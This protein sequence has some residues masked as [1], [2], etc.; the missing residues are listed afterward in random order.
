MTKKTIKKLIAGGLAFVCAVTA[1]IT[2]IVM[3]GLTAHDSDNINHN[4]QMVLG[5]FFGNGITLTANAEETTAVTLTY[6]NDYNASFVD[7]KS[8]ASIQP[9]GITIPANITLTAKSGYQFG[10][11]RVSD[12]SAPTSATMLS[13]NWVDTY[14]TTSDGTYG[15]AI[16]KTD[17]SDFDFSTD[18]IYIADYIDS[19]DT[20][21]FGSV[22]SGSG[23][24][25]PSVPTGV[26]RLTATITPA[27][28]SIQTVDWKVTWKN[29]S[30][31]WASGKTVTD[32]VNITPTEDGALTADIECQ[33]AFG[34]QV[35][36]TVTS[37]D[38]P[39]LTANCTVD[40]AKRI[41]KVHFTL[42][43][44]GLEPHSSAEDTLTLTF[45]FSDAFMLYSPGP[46]YEYSIGTV[47]DTYELTA[48]FYVD[49]DEEIFADI[50]AATGHV[51]TVHE[52]FLNGQFLGDPQYIRVFFKVDGRI[53][54]SSKLEEIELLEKYFYGHPEAVTKVFRMEIKVTGAYS[55]FEKDFKIAFDKNAL[56]TPAEGVGLDKSA[57]VL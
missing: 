27:S 25:T 41:E 53:L 22:D 10:F 57:I 44:N 23:S 40:Y 39:T 28:A 21:I 32:Y 49:Y 48:K 30:S 50:E 17:D 55:T 24:T 31:T 26:Q 8:R 33:Q 52:S 14:T 19:T 13:S 29:A 56:Y 38:D 12:I 3:G 54:T 18:S 43:P 9:Y 47:E 7:S 42:Q 11:Y 35:T 1:S 46:S 36:V 51:Y 34:E 45:G 4:N 2:A 16:K 15:I 6:G 20:T 37:R 5:N